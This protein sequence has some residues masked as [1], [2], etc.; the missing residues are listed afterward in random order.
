MGLVPISAHRKRR[1]ERQNPLFS[2]YEGKKAALS[3]RAL[4]RKQINQSLNLG[5]LGP[6][7]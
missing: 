2:S 6:K 4:T 7:N 5:F 3:K 1:E